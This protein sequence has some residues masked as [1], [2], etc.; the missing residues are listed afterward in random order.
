MLTDKEKLTLSSQG[1]SFY[2]W[3]KMVMIESGHLDFYPGDNLPDD[4]YIETLLNQKSY[5]TQWFKRVKFKDKLY[6]IGIEYH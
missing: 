3:N 2:D 5:D 4:Y 6:D 1:I